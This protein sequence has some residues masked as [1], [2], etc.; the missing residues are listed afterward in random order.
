MGVKMTGVKMMRMKTM[1][2]KGTRSPNSGFAWEMRP[3]SSDFSLDINIQIL[4]G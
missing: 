1:N 3:Q 4:Q 2:E